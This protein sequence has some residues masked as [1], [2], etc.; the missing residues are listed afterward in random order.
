MEIRAAIMEKAV[1]VPQNIKGRSQMKWYMHVIPML[2][3]LR[4]EDHIEFKASLNFTE[5]LRPA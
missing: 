3:R 4:Q 5:Y 1:G 2:G